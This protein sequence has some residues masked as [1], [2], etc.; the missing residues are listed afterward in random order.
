MQAGIDEI[1]RLLY[2]GSSFQISK[3]AL[4]YSEGLS[5][6]LVKKGSP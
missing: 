1:R 3:L 2:S 4:H 6:I 5:F